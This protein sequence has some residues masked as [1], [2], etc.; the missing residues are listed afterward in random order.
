MFTSW[1]YG[2]RFLTR[3]AHWKRASPAIQLR[4]THSWSVTVAI[5]ALV[6]E[7]APTPLWG[8]IEFVRGASR[9]AA[10]GFSTRRRPP[11]LRRFVAVSRSIIEKLTS[12]DCHLISSTRNYSETDREWTIECNWLCCNSDREWEQDSTRSRSIIVSDNSTSWSSLEY[13]S[14]EK[15]STSLYDR[16]CSSWYVGEIVSKLYLCD[17]V[18]NIFTS[19]SS[20]ESL[21]EIPECIR[22]KRTSLSLC[23]SWWRSIKHCPSDEPWDLRDECCWC[24]SSWTC[25]SLEWVV[26]SNSF[27][28]C[29]Y[30]SS[31]CYFTSYNCY[32]QTSSWISIKIRHKYYY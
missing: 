2:V 29:S 24:C 15:P 19:D 5:V 8:M 17:I 9:S 16:S 1:E 32:L 13:H 11:S 6:Y 22:L 14:V 10:C 31:Q 25:Y 23:S 18:W 12:R 28:L 26:R 3:L 30:M 4:I 27:K 20:S 21:F 7:T